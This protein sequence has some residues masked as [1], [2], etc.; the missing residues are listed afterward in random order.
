MN[1]LIYAAWIV[2]I[3]GSFMLL[4]IAFILIAYPILKIKTDKPIFH[5]EKVDEEL[6]GIGNRLHF[7]CEVL[8]ETPAGERIIA[9]HPELKYIHI[10]EEEEDKPNEI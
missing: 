5:E 7:I 8:S 6:E 10:G 1:I 2:S 9:E 4:S 3:L